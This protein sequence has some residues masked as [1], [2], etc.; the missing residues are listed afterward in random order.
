M[1]VHS[2]LM[3]AMLC[4]R[5][6]LACAVSVLSQYLD[7]PKATHIKLVK[8]LFQYVAANPDINLVYSSNEDKTLVG[9][10][11]ASYANE[12]GYFSRSGFGFMI[13][14][15]LV[16]WCSQKQ[17]IHAQSAA[18]AEYYAAVSASNEAV[19]LKQLMED[20]G[21]HQKTITIHEDN[22]ACIAL[23]KNPQDH[24]RTK[25]IQ[26]KYHVIRDYVNK[27]IIKL[28]YCPTKDQLADM[29][30]KGV[31]GCILRPMLKGFGLQSLK[32]HG[33]S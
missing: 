3:Y 30:T 10:A 29:F 15:S 17:P 2:I 12:E 21:N 22:Q 14:D 13:G 11:D 25:H 20:L 18:E 33:E 27:G 1:W 5:P 28:V 19:W 16:S 31:S 26:I 7:K 23:S 6:D 32:S 4:T 8:H 9:Y 24:K